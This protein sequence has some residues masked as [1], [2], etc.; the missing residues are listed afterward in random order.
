MTHKSAYSYKV[1]FKYLNELIEN[2]KIN[3]SFKKA[4]LMTDFE[5]PLRMVLKE[6]YPDCYLEGCYFHYSKAIWNK[7]KKIGLVNKKISKF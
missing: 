7:A 2:M 4:H 6:I 5:H 1:I 3:F